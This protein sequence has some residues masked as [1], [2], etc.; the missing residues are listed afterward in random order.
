ME[1]KAKE[2]IKKYLPVKSKY[3]DFDIFKALKIAI[4]NCKDE[5][6]LGLLSKCSYSAK[7]YN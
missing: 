1:Y 5:V 6:L 4:V 2:E 3:T 7:D